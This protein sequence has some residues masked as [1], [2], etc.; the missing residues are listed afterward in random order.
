[1]IKAV[2]LDLDDTLLANPTR[3]FTEN[4]LGL[5]DRFLRERIGLNG[6]I[7]RLLA[8]TRAIIQNTDPTRSNWQVFFE[9]LDPLL[10]VSRDVF[11]TAVAEFYRAAYP[12]LEALTQKRP[13]ARTLVEW[14]MAHDYTVAVATNPFFPRVAIEQRIAWAGLRDLPFALVTTLENMHYAKT[15]PAY[16]EEV[17]ARLGIQA[18]E[19]IMVGDDWEN[20]I[21]PARQAGLNTFWVISNG[22]APPPAG[23]IQPDGYGSLDDFACRVQDENWLETLTLRP[24]EPGQ[25]GPRLSGNIA[26]L[27]GIVA[28]VPPHVWPMRPDMEEWSPMEAL[29]HLAEAEREVQRPRLQ[30]IVETDNPFLSQPKEPPRPTTWV[31]PD[32]AWQMARQFADERLKTIAYLDSLNGATW[33]RPARH[34]IFGPTNLLEMANFLAQHDRL[35]MI[36]LCQTVN[37]CL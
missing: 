33:S 3:R 4:Y 23:D 36:Q 35:H 22:A 12:Q 21:I 27:F 6:V 15:H 8:G 34:Y 37:K 30:L 17:L 29:C 24:H 25:I 5:L 16:Y 10:T 31:C 13:G 9:T 2:L 20:D 28:E 18:D 14:L 26:A 7:E 32:S 1:M 19:A 11:D